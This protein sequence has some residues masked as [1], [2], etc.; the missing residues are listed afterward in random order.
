[1][2]VKNEQEIEILREGGRRLAR[3]LELVVNEVKPGVRTDE[4]D[5]FVLER[6]KENGDEPSLLGY[7]PPFA[8]RPYPST[9]CISVNDE[10]VHGIPSENPVV[11][12]EGDIVGFDLVMKHKDLH[13]DSALTVPVGEIDDVAKKLIVA[14]KGALEAGIAKTR[15]GNRIGDIGHAVET[16][17]RKYGFSVVEELC[18][19]GV[20]R[21]VHED[22]QIPN[23]GNSGEGETLE[24]GMVL[25]LEPMLNEGKYQVK[26]D[27]DGYTFRTR[28]GKRSAH[29][30]H[31]VLIGEDGPEVLTKRKEG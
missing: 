13:T 6:I 2:I 31:T 21:S 22:P 24:V 15:K 4:L 18:G 23:F 28:D 17:A 9:I 11:L 12:K 3:I 14:T 16:C 27:P 10:V 26:L 25:A 29:F 1:M 19:H 20:G 5:K 30:E 8:K 7:H